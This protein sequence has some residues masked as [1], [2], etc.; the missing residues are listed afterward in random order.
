MVNCVPSPI[1]M[2]G[3]TLIEASGGTA[4][5]LQTGEKV[6]GAIPLI[7]PMRFASKTSGLMLRTSL[8]A[9]RSL[10]AKQPWM[11]QETPIRGQQPSRSMT[12]TASYLQLSVLMLLA[13]D[14][15]FDR[16]WDF[17]AFHPRQTRLLMNNVGG[18]LAGRY[19]TTALSAQ[20]VAAV[21][22]AAGVIRLS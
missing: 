14:S 8:R 22:A 15:S 16:S 9:G 7:I 1:S 20:C 11:R 3:G 4:P 18:K 2:A 17:G 10:R 12:Q 19:A 5:A 21:T 13:Q 6:F